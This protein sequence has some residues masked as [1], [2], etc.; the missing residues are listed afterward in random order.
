V[1]LCLGHLAPGIVNLKPTLDQ[2]KQLSDRLAKGDKDALSALYELHAGLILAVVLRLV[3][4]RS[5][6]EDLVQETFLEAWRRATHYEPQRAH[7]VSWL[8]TIAKSRAIDRLRNRQVASR[9]HEQEVHES[10][11]AS[12]DV[13]EALHQHRESAVVRRA[14]S[15]LPQSQRELLEL[16]WSKG[17]SQSEIAASTGIPLGTVKTRTRQ[18]LVTLA[19]SLRTR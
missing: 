7:V 3:R 18:A 8:V 1:P 16:A 12:V 17:M 6:A 5:E 10:P 2:E 19:G 13:V 15:E 14:V 9:V 4:N 11:S